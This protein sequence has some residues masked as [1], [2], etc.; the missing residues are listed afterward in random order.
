MNRFLGGTIVAM[1]LLLAGCNPLSSYSVT[2]Q[3]INNALAKHEQ[4]SKDIGLPGIAD[5]HIELS[6]LT[7]QIGRQ[8]PGKVTLSGDAKL[9]FNS[10]FGNQKADLKLTLKAQPAFNAQQ[11]A[12]YLKEMEVTDAQIEPK[13]MASLLQTLMPYLNQSLRNYFNQRP[14][15]VL[16]EDRSK[17]EA[18]AKS[19]AKGIEVKPG[20]I[21][22]QF[23]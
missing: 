1:G 13:K 16:S 8:E 9:D 6:N 12:I 2:E 20:S 19:Q 10:L 18:L 4:F 11:G 17:G 23:K 22:I 7:S 21:V 5:A 14:A 15:Y 3:E